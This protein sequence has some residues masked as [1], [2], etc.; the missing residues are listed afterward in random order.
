MS[1]LLVSVAP[2]FLNLL[3]QNGVCTCVWPRVCFV[4]TGI[5]LCSCVLHPPPLTIP[6]YLRA[7]RAQPRGTQLSHPTLS[8]LVTWDSPTSPSSAI[9]VPWRPLWRH[10]KSVPTVGL[11]HHQHLRE[12]GGSVGSTSLCRAGG[13]YCCR[14]CI[15]QQAPLSCGSEEG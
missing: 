14:D 12:D 5:L 3:S 1:S 15:H 13:L 8:S 11:P 9:H 7:Q 10:R 6:W 2:L 4:V